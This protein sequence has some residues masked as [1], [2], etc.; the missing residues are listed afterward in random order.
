MSKRFWTYTLLAVV[1]LAAY[2]VAWPHVPA[3]ALRSAHSQPAATVPSRMV[4]VTAQG[5]TFHDPSCK[6]IHGKIEM[7]PAEEAIRRGYSPCV[8]CMREALK[9]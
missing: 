8:R 6:Y 9:R 5:K 2:D 1:M 4:A 3:P 7:M